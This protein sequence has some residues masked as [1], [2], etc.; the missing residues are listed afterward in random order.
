MDSTILSY[1]ATLIITLSLCTVAAIKQWKI[2]LIDIYRYL[3]E[4]NTI[5]YTSELDRFTFNSNSDPKDLLIYNKNLT[6]VT[7]D[8]QTM[9]MTR[10][11]CLKHCFNQTNLVILTILTNMYTYRPI[12]QREVLNVLTHLHVKI[13]TTKDLF[14]DHLL[15]ILPCAN[16]L[17]TI[18]YENGHLSSES[19]NFIMS[20]RKLNLLILENVQIFNYKTYSIMLFNIKARTLIIKIEN[21]ISGKFNNH[22]R[23]LKKP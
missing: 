13:N 3:T 5:R 14:L 20:M 10:E 7:V 21:S 8:T 18:I 9:N 15:P 11:D 2:Q 16:N 1:I 19:M 22:Q 23:I 12:K 4:R 17:E 6:N